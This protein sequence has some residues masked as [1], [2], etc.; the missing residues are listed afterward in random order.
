MVLDAQRLKRVLGRFHQGL[1][2]YE[3]ALN[4]LNVYPVPDGDTGTNMALTVRSVV[5]ACD[6]ASTID[7]VAEA[8][9]RGSLMGARGNSGVIL[10]QILRGLAETF[11]GT[12]AVGV[13]E[14]V[15]GLGR[16][17]DS[18]YASVVRPVE[19]TILTVAR[20]AATGARE[21]AT[22][23][24]DPSVGPRA[25]GRDDLTAFLD[26][27]HGRAQAA[28][29]ST[30]ELLP[31]LARA[32]VVDAGGAGLLLLIGAFV[33]ELGGPEARLPA[34]VVAR[35]AE[36]SAMNLDEPSAGREQR[37]GAGVAGL[38]YEV[39]FFLETDDDRID[40]FRSTWAELGDS[41]VVVGGDGLYNCHIHTDHIG[42]SI[43]TGIELGR[44]HD[45]RVTDLL[46]QAGRLEG[47]AD[48]SPES[49]SD[50]SAYE[51]LGEFADADPAVVAVAAGSGLVSMFR[52][53]G[54][55]RVVAGG[56]SMNPSTQDLVAAVEAVAAG[57][58][59]VLPNNKNIVPV[60]RQVAGLTPKSVAVVATRSVPE[61][62]AAMLAYAPGMELSALANAMEAEAATV[63]P[64]EITRAVR[65]A[66]TNAGYVQAGAWIGLSDGEIVV[67]AADELSALEG[68]VAELYTESH[69]LLTVMVGRDATAGALDLLVDRLR[70]SRPGLGVE[71]VEGGQPV[72]PYL[73]ALE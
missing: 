64:G 44:P 56:Q 70:A 7:D 57:R 38:R 21:T 61:G 58:V 54:A 35:A 53:L 3:D 45:I 43:E 71:L 34:A 28:L 31:A 5:E 39:M 52:D 63:V 37:E 12:E 66:E 9:A 30:P 67:I 42:R 16:A 4:R 29:E 26:R 22:W 50:E 20:E 59:V 40:T 49:P 2:R 27:V 10:S 72:Y 62:I 65:D 47:E 46:E 25:E 11:R 60:A 51:P 1:V 6:A 13:A 8:M 48:R 36:R 18:A 69:E 19:G 32:G 24:L 15:T 55:A 14:M 23:V 17:S 33:E 68:L 41:I 73:L